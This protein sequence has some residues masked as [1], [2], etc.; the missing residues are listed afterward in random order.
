MPV[1][2]M[3]PYATIVIPTLDR[4]ATLQMAVASAQNQTVDKIEIMIVLDG[5]TQECR[6]IAWGTASKDPRVTVL[7]LPKGQGN[8]KDN[9]HLAISKARANRI[10]YSDD[11]DLL[12]PYHIE[13]L[14]ALLDVADV[15]D[16]RVATAGL[17]FDLHLGPC[18]TSAEHPRQ[19]LASHKHKAIF[20]TH[21]AHTKSAYERFASWDRD[22]DVSARPV[23]DFMAGFAG[24]SDCIWTYCPEVTAVS[25]HGANRTFMSPQARRS[26]VQS[27]QEL[28]EQPSSLA[29]LVKRSSSVVHFLRLLSQDDADCDDFEQYLELV[30]S[31]NDVFK[32]ELARSSFALS[33]R[34]RP[35]EELVV[36][37]IE[38]ATRPAFVGY[39]VQQ[40]A[41]LLARAFSPEE[42]ASFARVAMQKCEPNH[43][44][45]LGLMSVLHYRM[46]DKKQARALAEKALEIG[47]DVQGHLSGLRD[48][49]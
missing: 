3:A 27:W 44:G 16:S 37:L 9:V 32:D 7:D 25:L 17:Q 2:E 33:R 22:G 30:G 19:L 15:A 49:S 1:G 28:I 46:G 10:F 12:L 43:A 8:G 45:V 5:A 18:T 13:K 48:R 21:F 39:Q 4:S 6:E 42:S 38:V 29:A 40:L 47:P 11:D 35:A 31:Y 36:Q 26:E 20:D 14:G 34:K 24:N 41:N 23:W